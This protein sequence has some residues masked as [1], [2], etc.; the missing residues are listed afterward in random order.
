MYKDSVTYGSNQYDVRFLYD[1]DLA[2]N[3]EKQPL[4]CVEKQR[5]I[6][7]FVKAGC[8]IGTIRSPQCSQVTSSNKFS[9]VACEKVPSVNAFLK[10]VI[11]RSKSKLAVKMT[12]SHK[13]Q[14]ISTFTKHQRLDRLRRLRIKYKNRGDEIRRLKVRLIRSS[15]K[16]K[17]VTDLRTEYAM[18]GDTKGLS[19]TLKV[20]Y[21]KG[22][23]SNKKNTLTFIQNLVEN[24]NKKPKGKMYTSF[25]KSLYEVVKIWGG[26]RMV[27]LQSLNLDGPDEKTVRH[28]VQKHMYDQDFRN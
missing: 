5:V 27:K 8:S 12:N 23:L 10:Q 15:A 14:N 3:N 4:W 24:L 7:E 6:P 26:N 17:K 18:R 22:L 19:K 16:L 11:R 25:T 13:T 1:K 28:E 2:V 20:A 9:C 21:D